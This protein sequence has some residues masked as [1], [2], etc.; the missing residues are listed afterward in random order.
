MIWGIGVALAL[1]STLW[2]LWPLFRQSGTAM[3]ADRRALNAQAYQEGLAEID[4]QEQQTGLSTAAA[5][6]LRAE[7]AARLIS[8][9]EHKESERLGPSA[10]R[11]NVRIGWAACLLLPAVAAGIYASGEGRQVARQVELGR[12]NPQ[13]AIE[14]MVAGL[15]ER[16][17]ESPDDA[18]GWA[19]LGRSYSTLERYPQAAEAYKQAN[20]R[21]A[22]PQAN[23]LVGEAEAWAFANQRNL[24]GRARQLLDQA[25]SLDAAHERALWY[26]GLAHI[27]AGEIEAGI[28]FWRRLLQQPDLPDEL[29]AQLQ[30]QIR[31]L[32]GAA[33]DEAAPPQDSATAL[34]LQIEVQLSPDLGDRLPDGGALF[35]FAR[36][37]GGAPMPMAVKRISGAQLPLTVNLSDADAM[38]PQHRLSNASRWELIAR[39]SQAGT[40]Q[41]QAGDLQGQ[42]VLDRS[43]A[44][45]RQ[46]LVIDQLLD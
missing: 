16:L 12:D 34:T 17:D 13:L 33:T 40:V 9:A 3:T 23:W 32:G 25:L 39:W 8:E 29:R 41:P 44:G 28:G 15:A 36:E 46:I 43:E 45:T 20:A 4:R 10:E 24:Q 1:A 21:A 11:F 31:S 27:Q 2:L 30:A 35:V 26:A 37:P 19:M 38:M 6:A 18:A 22:P 14:A 7:L 42:S 5:E